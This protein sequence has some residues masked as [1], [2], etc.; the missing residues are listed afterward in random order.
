MLEV[1]MLEWSC[2]LLVNAVVILILE[3]I[4]FAAKTLQAE[5]SY[6]A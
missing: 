1:D 5:V 4:L 6:L 3:Q 2:S